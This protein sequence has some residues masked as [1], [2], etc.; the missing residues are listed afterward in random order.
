MQSRYDI[1]WCP[2]YTVLECVAKQQRCVFLVYFR[3][4][5]LIVFSNL[6]RVFLGNVVLLALT[7]CDTES[8]FEVSC[9]MEHF[10]KYALGILFN[11]CSMNDTH[12]TTVSGQFSTN[13]YRLLTCTPSGVL[14]LF[15]S[16]LHKGRFF[17][18]LPLIHFQIRG[19]GFLF[20]KQLHYVLLL[21][22]CNSPKSFSSS[23]IM[24][25]KRS[26]SSHAAHH[27][28]NISFLT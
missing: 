5:P 24:G 28:H 25:I 18:H 11:I 20:L 27:L 12:Y 17:L 10:S 22:F 8:Y 15:I 7:S 3:Y 6:S 9:S 13:M 23:F 16:P 19:R 4:C 21:L 14:Y 2:T 26:R 1:A